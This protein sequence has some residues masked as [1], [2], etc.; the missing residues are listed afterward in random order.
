MLLYNWLRFAFLLIFFR[1][2]DTSLFRK[3]CSKEGKKPLSNSY[4]DVEPGD[5]MTRRAPIFNLYI[6][7]RIK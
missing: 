4:L 2:V 6:I 5:K 3:I 7:L 1:A